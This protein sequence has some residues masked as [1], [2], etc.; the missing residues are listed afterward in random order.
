MKAGVAP[1]PNHGFSVAIA[2]DEHTSGGAGGSAGGGEMT[3]GGK[4][5]ST[6]A[7]RRGLGPKVTVVVSAYLTA[8]SNSSPEIQALSGSPH[9]LCG[10]QHEP[11]ACGAQ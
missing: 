5:A 3:E 10:L 9:C 2:L 7:V 1:N 4:V 6:S 8:L 11:C